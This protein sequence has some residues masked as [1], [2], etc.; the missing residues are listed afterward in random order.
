[1]RKNYTGGLH[2]EKLY[3]REITLYEEE[4]TQERDYIGKNYTRQTILYKKEIIQRKN[5]I[6]K[7]LYGKKL[8]REE[9]YG[10]KLPRE[11]LYR[12][13]LH[14]EKLHREELYKRGTISYKKKTIKRET[15]QKA[16]TNRR[17]IQGEI[18]QKRDCIEEG[19]YYMKEGL[20]RK[21]TIW[22]EI[23]QIRNT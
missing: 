6:E 1:M 20:Y 3:R 14:G 7:R 4:A 11:E 23:T 8:L 16:T 5:Y 17:L 19:L 12:E 13:K 22:E 2:R 21:G 15:I 10:K 9:L 18:I